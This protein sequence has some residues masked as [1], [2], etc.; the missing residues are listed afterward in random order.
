[1]KEGG[2][3]MGQ[4]MGE[5]PDLTIRLHFIWGFLKSSSIE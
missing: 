1:M 2:S 5:V 3:C 4:V